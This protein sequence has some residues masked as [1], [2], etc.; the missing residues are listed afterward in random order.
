MS[1]LYKRVG[2]DIARSVEKS[3]REHNTVSIAIKKDIPMQIAAAIHK[4]NNEDD[5]RFKSM[6]ESFDAKLNH[7]KDWIEKMN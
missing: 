7:V 2:A 1:E 6:V 3:N 4:K 5:R